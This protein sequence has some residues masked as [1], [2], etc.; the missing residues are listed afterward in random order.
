MEYQNGMIEY[1]NFN[2]RGIYQDKSLVEKQLAELS[3]DKGRKYACQNFW[4]NCD[5]AIFEV[6]IDKPFDTQITF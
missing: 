1:E 5:Y 4:S 2:L 6:D 3:I